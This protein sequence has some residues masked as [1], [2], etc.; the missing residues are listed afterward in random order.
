MPKAIAEC[1]FAYVRLDAVKPPLV[2]PYEG[3]FKV[4]ERG[5]KTFKLQKNGRPWVVSIDRL[6]PAIS[7]PTDVS[8]LPGSSRLSPHA[9]PFVPGTRRHH[10]S[11]WFSRPPDLSADSS[12]VL[13]ESAVP[14]PDLPPA[15]PPPALAPP[16][17]APPAPVVPEE[18]PVAQDVEQN[19]VRDLPTTRSGRV[20]RPPDRYGDWTT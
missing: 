10:P 11:D 4:L 1:Q 2:R 16:V 6:K 20:S 15:P 9:L 8:F 14:Q 7:P 19:V 17:P 18:H 3:P 13:L 12:D 5:V